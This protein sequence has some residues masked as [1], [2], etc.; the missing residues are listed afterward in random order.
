[1]LGKGVGR[2][3]G[4]RGVLD[5]GSFTLG[6]SG[7]FAL[8]RWS[9]RETEPWGV[10][11]GVTATGVLVEGG[12]PKAAAR[13]PPPLQRAAGEENFGPKSRLLQF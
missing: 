11:G 13:A 9:G 1:M 7:S 3:G 5:A 10:D 8:G 12:V 6:L 4:R 2:R